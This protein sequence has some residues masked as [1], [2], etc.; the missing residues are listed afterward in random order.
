M[1]K[2]D[3]AALPASVIALRSCSWSKF[4]KELLA[5]GDDE[6]IFCVDPRLRHVVL[7]PRPHMLRWRSCWEQSGSWQKC[8]DSARAGFC[9]WQWEVG[10]GPWACGFA[11]AQSRAGRRFSSQW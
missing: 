2:L 9:G 4:S 7:W 3:D 8:E 1:L 5:A 11:T 10:A 6:G